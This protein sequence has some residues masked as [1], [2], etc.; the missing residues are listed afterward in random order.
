MFHATAA[1]QNMSWWR[2]LAMHFT[3]DIYSTEKLLLFPLWQSLH[4]WQFNANRHVCPKFGKSFHLYKWKYTQILHVR[5]GEEEA[6]VNS[7]WNCNSGSGTVRV[8]HREPTWRQLS[9]LCL[10]RLRRFIEAWLLLLGHRSAPTEEELKTRRHLSACYITAA[11]MAAFCS[12]CLCWF[13]HIT[14]FNKYC[15]S[16]AKQG[17]SSSF[18]HVRALYLGNGWQ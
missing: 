18:L 17:A 11:I 14:G 13:V 7:Y 15:Y 9:S 12:V 4:H 1:E 3:G 10:E 5:A 2:T 6:A 16:F 8:T